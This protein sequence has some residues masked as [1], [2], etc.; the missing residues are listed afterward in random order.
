MQV[1]ARGQVVFDGAKERPAANPPAWRPAQGHDPALLFVEVSQV[2]E[3]DRIFRHRRAGGL[4][5]AEV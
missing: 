1:G 4:G 2:V 3:A 5:N